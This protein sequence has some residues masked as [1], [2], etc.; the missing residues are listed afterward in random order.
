ME[1]RIERTFLHPELSDVV[2]LKQHIDHGG[3]TTDL[4]VHLYNGNSFYRRVF[5]LETKTGIQDIKIYT[6]NLRTM[7]GHLD[8]M[9]LRSEYAK[10]KEFHGDKL[11]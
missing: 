7:L 3:L 8:D 11:L 2:L 5:D 10:W 1:T 9:I 4:E 6:E